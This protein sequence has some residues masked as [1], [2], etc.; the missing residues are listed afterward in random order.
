MQLPRRLQIHP[1]VCLLLL[2]ARHQILDRYRG[3]GIEDIIDWCFMEYSDAQCVGIF[4]FM[5]E[6]LIPGWIKCFLLNAGAI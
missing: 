6:R 5:Y 3:I 2:I 4:H 1:K